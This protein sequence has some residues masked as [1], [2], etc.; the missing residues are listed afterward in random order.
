M[1][2]M[3]IG[4]ETL[5]S[6]LVTVC[7]WKNGLGPA[8]VLHHHGIQ[9]V[10]DGGATIT[11]LMGLCRALIGIVDWYTAL[12]EFK[13]RNTAK[14]VVLALLLILNLAWSVVKT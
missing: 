10:S 13:L 11:N 6:Q 9:C 8:L 4:T 12:G 7:T 1:M 14:C 2:M 5:V 3:L